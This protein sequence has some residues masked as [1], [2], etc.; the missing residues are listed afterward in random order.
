[1]DNTEDPKRPEGVVEQPGGPEK[2]PAVKVK[3]PYTPPKLTCYGTIRDL[4]QKI[5]KSGSKD[6]GVR[7]L[8]RTGI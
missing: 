5:G 4:T 8:T 1:M 7:V 3:K 2:V 6:S